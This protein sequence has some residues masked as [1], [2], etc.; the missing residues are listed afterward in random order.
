MAKRQRRVFSAAFKAEVVRRHLLQR[1]SAQDICTEHDL[2]PLLFK[3]WVREFLAAGA[4][5]FDRRRAAEEFRLRIRLGEL[6][7]ELARRRRLLRDVR[8][9][10][11]EPD[12]PLAP[13]E[14]C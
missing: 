4:D 9:A 8:Q 14:N 7:M 11:A 6:E 10:L 1:V 13:A 2:H 12:P 5:A 3:R